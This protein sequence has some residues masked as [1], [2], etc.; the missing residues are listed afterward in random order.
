MVESHKKKK[1]K[2]SWERGKAM[3]GWT[4]GGGGGAGGGGGG[5]GGGGVKS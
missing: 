5:G 4:R 3:P 2:V 1:I